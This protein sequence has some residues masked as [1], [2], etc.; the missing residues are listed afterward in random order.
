MG[1]PTL[2]IDAELGSNELALNAKMRNRRKGMWSEA[3]L[4]KICGFDNPTWNGYGIIWNGKTAEWGERSKKTSVLNG[5]EI[6][7][8]FAKMYLWQWAAMAFPFMCQ[9]FTLP[10]IGNW[11]LE[12]QIL[13]VSE[14][15][16]IKISNIEQK[17]RPPQKTGIM[18]S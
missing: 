1:S 17:R 10:Y 16:K 4:K 13:Q 18:A 6:Q 14:T 11:L 12:Q 7:F 2:S 8:W 3:G 5:D 15:L 9:S